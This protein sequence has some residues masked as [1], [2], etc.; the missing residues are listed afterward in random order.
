MTIETD[1]EKQITAALTQL[2]AAFTAIPFNQMLGLKLDHISA[3]HITMSFAMKT[4]LVGNYMHGILHGGVISSVLDM[5]GG[6]MAMA[7]A[8]A[9]HQDKSQTEM[10][11]I[12]ANCSTIDLQVSFLSP[13]KGDLFIAK[14]WLL[15]S[16]HHITFT[17][18]ELFNEAETLVAT[19]TG[20]YLIK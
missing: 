2:T 7:A 10:I 1:K 5:A 11:Q 18:M 9:R 20:T 13:G 6:M 17:R 8:I 12:V 14:S 16:G 19:A 4:E 3:D 15:K